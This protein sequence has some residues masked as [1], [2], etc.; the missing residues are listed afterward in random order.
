MASRFDSVT[1]MLYLDRLGG[2]LPVL[3]AAMCGQ[4]CRGVILIPTNRQPCVLGGDHSRGGGIYSG[5]VGL[6]RR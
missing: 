4:G 1:S 6:A 3:P 2:R 5:M